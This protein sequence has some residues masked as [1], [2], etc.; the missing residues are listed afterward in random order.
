MAILDGALKAQ[1]FPPPGGGL[2]QE[3]PPEVLAG[4]GA[5][6]RVSRALT[7]TGTL[8]ELA[9]GAL[10]E[11]RDGLD[12][13][14]AALYLPDPT[15][16][17]TL[18]RYVASSAEWVET[19]AR[20]E[21]AF[22]EEAWRLAI[23]SGLPL[24]FHEPASWLVANPFEPAASS[25]L[26]LPL[27]S[28]RRMVGAVIAAASSAIVLE[29]ATATVLSLLGDQI[30]AGIATARLRQELQLAE[31]ERERVRLAAD[32]HDGLAQDLALALREVA[33]LEDDPSPEP[34]AAS[35]DRLREAVASAHRLVRARL[36]D[37]AVAAPLGGLRAAVEE[38]CDRHRRR[39]LTLDLD[40]DV[41][42]AAADVS[43]EAI[44]VV[45][46]VLNEA[47]TNVA[48]HARAS[49][50]VVRL[51]LDE[52]RMEVVVEDDGVGYRVD[53][54]PGPGDGHFGLTIMR[55]R[56]ASAGGE[57]T[58]EPRPGGG[59]RVRARL[60]V[61]SPAVASPGPAP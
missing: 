3:L 50:A 18:S 59:T 21:L 10:E 6:S 2:A 56:V 58:V 14:L 48:K 12:L 22:D 20:E 8:A 1:P 7:G 32:V 34:A 15:A 9:Y 39:G 41:H 51:E 46:R 17:T 26:V 40:L 19:A 36:E 55:R 30:S 11:M 23:G 33:F 31:F 53:R 60:P 49:S 42:G 35:R 57:V 47:L 29:P 45:I 44:A 25:W 43:P 27:V 52:Q 61:R 16:R 37:L 24:V 38:A 4:L 28:A 5:I 54:A 13:D